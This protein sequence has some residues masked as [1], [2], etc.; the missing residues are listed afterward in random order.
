MVC[1]VYYKH[2]QNPPP[3]IYIMNRK[4]CHA[5]RPKRRCYDSRDWYF[6]SARSNAVCKGMSIKATILVFL[7]SFQ[8]V[9][10]AKTSGM[11]LQ[12]VS[13]Q[14]SHKAATAVAKD[15]KLTDMRKQ[16]CQ[17]AIHR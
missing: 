15:L 12:C 10:A 14:N 1:L 11:S 3:K 2:V 4:R 5:T 13:I 6:C 7:Y 9:Y 8:M 16:M 17:G